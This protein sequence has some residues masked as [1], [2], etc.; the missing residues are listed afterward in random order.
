[1]NFKPCLGEIKKGSKKSKERKNT[2]YNIEMLCR[3]RK[4]AIKCF[5]DYSSMMS[6]A[7]DKATKETGLKILTQKHFFLHVENKLTVN[8]HGKQPRQITAT[9]SHGKKPRQIIAANSH[10]KKLRQI[11]T[12]NSH[13]K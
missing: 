6:E 10:G 1:M 8:S 2:I 3:A 13:G 9:N 7:K 11:A 12:A 5:Y 4:E